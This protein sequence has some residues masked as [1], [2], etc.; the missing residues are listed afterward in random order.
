MLRNYYFRY[1]LAARKE[2]VSSCGRWLSSLK[3][4]A[5]RLQRVLENNKVQHVQSLLS[6]HKDRFKATDAVKPLKN[7][8]EL[9]NIP[10]KDEKNISQHVKTEKVDP[11]VDHEDVEGNKR[12]ASPMDSEDLNFTNKQLPMK[13]ERDKNRAKTLALN[14]KEIMDDKDHKNMIHSQIELN[15]GIRDH[16]INYDH[17]SKFISHQNSA[18]IEEDRFRLGNIKL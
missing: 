16:D 11:K 7:A 10:K 15:G 18:F 17:P 14:P 8:T 1:G 5:L 4:T 3:I 2:S 13:F 9:L 12:P 6:W